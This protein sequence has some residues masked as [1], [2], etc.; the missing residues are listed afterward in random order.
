MSSSVSADNASE[1]YTQSGKIIAIDTPLGADALLLTSLEGEDQLSRCFL[2]TIEFVT[3]TA[4]DEVRSLIG[5]RIT[6]WLQNKLETERQP[7]NGFIRRIID[8]PTKYPGFTSYRA[9]VIPRL[10]FLECTSDCRIFQAMTY[11]EIIRQVLEDYGVADVSFKLLKSDYPVEDYCVQY[12]ESALTFISRLMEHVG[13]FY[14]HTHTEQSHTLVITDTNEFTPFMAPRLLNL[15]HNTRQ[16]EIQAAATDTVFRPGVWSLSDYDFEGPTKFMKQRAQT[17]LTVAMM[18]Q[19]E[20]FDFPGGYTDQHV[21]AWLTELRMQAE[22]AEFNRM[23]GVA[24]AP[25]MAPGYRFEFDR[26]NGQPPV[27]YLL[28]SL[29]HHAFEHSY[30]GNREGPASEYS[31]DFVAIKANVPF[32]PK[33]LTPKSIMPG[34]QTAT[35]VSGSADDLIQTDYYGRV[36]VHFHWD[37]RGQPSSGSTSCWLRVAQNSAGGG[38]GGVSVPHAGHEVIVDFLEGDPDRPLI[39]GRVHNADKNPPLNLPSDKHKSITRDHGNNKFVME[40]AAGNQHMTLIA[41][42]KL[43]LFSIKTAAQSLSAGTEGADF[44]L[45]TLAQNP[46]GS[47]Y[48]QLQSAIT[49]AYSDAITTAGGGATTADYI[50]SQADVTADSNSV[51]ESNSNSYAGADM[52]SWCQGTSNAWVGQGS[53]SVTYQYAYS[54]VF[55]A[56]ASFVEGNSSSIVMGG[57]ESIVFPFNLGITLGVNVGITSGLNVGFTAAGNVNINRGKNFTAVFPGT[58]PDEV[59][60]NATIAAAITA[61]QTL[62]GPTP[63]WALSTAGGVTITAVTGVTVVAGVAWKTSATA[64]AALTSAAVSVEG[65]ATLALKAPAVTLDA[66]ASFQIT[67]PA[68]TINGDTVMIG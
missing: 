27:T 11:P 65:A 5:Q 50:P 23:L 1:G 59:E 45:P 16:G 51:T 19:H 22:E 26:D 12:R 54:N 49:A 10:W 47:A 66:S 48:G 58:D 3:K 44:T 31:N 2:Y 28:T 42:R 64:T 33:R 18:P 55:G 4:D 41:P 13:I 40:G 8:Q 60:T 56:S 15:S 37:R 67:S 24:S 34:A 61:A 39:I 57:S 9:E 21:G 36:K 53:N 62:T 6:L 52:N 14:F 63:D 7:V 32:R 29:N 20:R 43:N 35:V 17:S 25:S 68:V 38:Y 30:F 46:N